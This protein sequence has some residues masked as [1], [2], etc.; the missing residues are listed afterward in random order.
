MIVTVNIFLDHETKTLEIQL[1]RKEKLLQEEIKQ[2]AR[3]ITSNLAFVIERA[4]AQYD[5]SYIQAIITMTS[6]EV[7]EFAFLHL[8][9]REGTVLFSSN[10][11][12]QD[13]KLEQ[14]THI[15]TT[16]IQRD[17]D[18]QKTPVL[19]TIR[20][21]RPGGKVWGTLY[22]GVKYTA[23]LA[24]ISESRRDVGQS[25]HEVKMFGL[26][27]GIVSVLIG[28]LI[29]IFTVRYVTDPLLTLTGAVQRISKDMTNA[30]IPTFIRNDEISVLSDAFRNL[31]Q[32]IRDYLKELQEMNLLLE[33][34]VEERTKEL[35][36]KAHD[37]SH[38]NRKIIDSI[39]YAKNIQHSILP[40]DAQVTAFFPEHFILWYPKD[41]VGG[42]F[43]WFETFPKG[44]LISAADC[45][46]HG[47]PGALMSMA[48][49]SALR[50]VVTADNCDQPASVINELNRNIRSSLRQE[51]ND[52]K[53]NDGLDIGM[54]FVSNNHDKIVF[55]GARMELWYINAGVLHKQQGDKQ[56]VGYV[57]SKHQFNYTNHV[58]DVESEVNCYLST[59]GYYDQVGEKFISFSKKRLQ[60]LIMANFSEPHNVQRETFLSAYHD[61]RGSRQQLDD[62]T[63]V[64]FKVQRKKDAGTGLEKLPTT[65]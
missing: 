18:W 65:E 47:V 27:I 9:D 13:T 1:A 45:T 34:K 35:A 55:A 17:K 24:E 3:Y 61:Y 4:L 22:L 53:S 14:N 56:S 51:G 15:P 31:I 64:G 48:A 19:E 39:N 37:L 58:I 6:E 8:T 42:D 23:I 16:I 43:Y 62:L 57:K 2:Q 29:V 28:I 60:K 40:T 20:P 63:M 26:G 54:C 5:F 44:C 33:H 49:Y 52:S 59:D 50:K 36:N 11:K 7:S 21:L 25:I 12:L 10:E 38:A 30:Q 46:G 32:R 41:I